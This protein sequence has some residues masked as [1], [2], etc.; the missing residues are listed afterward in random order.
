[1]I[2]DTRL[3]KN[4]WR[5]ATALF[6]P[7]LAISAFGLGTGAIGA[8]EKQGDSNPADHIS[9]ESPIK[10]VIILIGENR[11]LDHT[12]GVYKPKGKGQTISNILSKSIVNIDGTPGPN[13]SLAQQFSVAAQSSWYF[14]APDAAKIPYSPTNL[15]P[16]PNTN[17]A[18]SAASTNPITDPTAPFA[19]VAIVESLGEQDINPGDVELLTTG[20]T[21]L[22]TG[23]LGGAAA[24]LQPGQCD[25]GESDRLPQ[26]PVRLRHGHLLGN[27]QERRQ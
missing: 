13:F 1:M 22:P 23:V 16:Q 6:T 26:R 8:P 25:Q 2:A 3:R 15:M 27:Q 18:P 10:H 24:G 4:H 12:F 19:T 14:G 21:G 7:I 17:G 20:A 5:L 9:T 11:G